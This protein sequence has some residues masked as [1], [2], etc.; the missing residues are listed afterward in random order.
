MSAIGLA[1]FDENGNEVPAT[2]ENGLKPKLTEEERKYIAI[3]HSYEYKRSWDIQNRRN[4][5]NWK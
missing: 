2:R 4:K 3:K 1:M 5:K